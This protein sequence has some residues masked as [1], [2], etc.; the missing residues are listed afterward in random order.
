[1][2]VSTLK[3]PVMASWL[4]EGGYRLDAPPFVSGA[5]EAK[6]LLEKS[7][8]RRDLLVDLTAGPKGGIF[9]G[10]MFRRNYVEDSRF[11]VPFLTS[12]NILL[13][14]LKHIGLLSKKDAQSARLAYL[15]IE[16]GMTLISCSGSIGRTAYV[17]ADMAGLWSSQDVMKIVPNRARILPGYLY[18]FLASK[19]GNGQITAATYGAIIPHIEPQHLMGMKVA[20]FDSKFERKIHG[21]VAEAANLRAV[22]SRSLNSAIDGVVQSLSQRAP[23]PR[24]KER[25]TF[26]VVS[27]STM[28]RTKRLEGFYHNRIAVELDKWVMSHPSGYAALGDI[29][30]VF[31][32]P[33]FKHIY[34]DEGYGI[35][36]FTSG[37]IFQLDRIAAKFLSKTQTVNI[38]KY[39]LE[40]GWVLLARSGQLG[41]IIGRPQFAD[42]ALHKAATSDH[43]IRIVVQGNVPPGYL[44][45][46]LASDEIGYPLITRTMSGSSVPALW[47]EHL[48]Q[49]AVVKADERAMWSVHKEVS[50]AFEKRVRATRLECE[51][52]RLVEDAIQ[53]A[54]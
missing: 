31:D 34:V 5:L 1:V 15:R 45:A 51:A 2:K 48:R 21:L 6:K 52:R 35:P 38:E 10:P 54:L 18:A 33:P 8:L 24:A 12:G 32:V 44:Y 13:A 42:S 40:S 30:N 14:D 9:N 43:V 47:P 39:I 28:E 41:G 37:E 20:R 49:V 11:G 16:E 50:A 36:F 22:A 27:A 19:F 46:Y 7:H 23:V 4:E 29:A 17:R 26:E 25:S 53:E 3:N